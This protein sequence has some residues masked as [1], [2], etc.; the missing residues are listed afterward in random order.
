MAINT[1]NVLVGTAQ[2]YFAPFG[3]TTPTTPEPPPADTIAK[4]A[5]WAGNW[6]A[7]GATEQGV[8]LTVNKKTTDIMVEEQSTPALVTVDTETVSVAVSLAEDTIA[9]MQLSYGGGTITTVAATATLIGKTTLQLALGLEL[10]SV[11]FEGVN[12]KGFWRR[13]Y[14]PKCVSV[15]SV[16]TSYRRAAAAR[17]YPT[18]I[19]AICA[20]TQ[21]QIVDMVAAKT[22]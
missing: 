18:T 12:S 14:I 16:D 19:R 3:K 8:K 10:L 20:P 11:G 13:V 9:N 7:I 1:K 4:G 21:I 22:A 6:V 15:A 5:A 2:M 17:L